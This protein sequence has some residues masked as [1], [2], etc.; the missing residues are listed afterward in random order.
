ME[1]SWPAV[2]VSDVEEPHSEVG[3][4]AEIGAGEESIL[5]VEDNRE[6]REASTSLLLSLGYRVRP[7]ATAEEALVAAADG[8][9]PDL[10]L[11]DLVLPDLGGR[12]LADRLQ[13]RFPTLQ[14]LFV[15][16]YSDD[17]ELRRRLKEGRAVL[18]EKPYTSQALLQKVREILDGRSES[19]GAARQDTDG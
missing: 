10:L 13:Q 14:V 8:E 1:I 11:A 19:P 12:E 3:S 2:S 7:A 18:L 9:P 17:A 15:T 16:G 5:L 4:T 6:L